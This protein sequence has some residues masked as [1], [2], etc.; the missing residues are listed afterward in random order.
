MQEVG[1]I[2]KKIRVENGFT[3]EDICKAA[4]VGKNALI[5]LENGRGVSPTTIRKV[6]ETLYRKSKEIEL[7]DILKL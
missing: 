1:Y 5:N 3:Q 6:K 4:G 2:L 7:C